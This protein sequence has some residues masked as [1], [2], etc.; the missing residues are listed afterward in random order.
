[1]LKVTILWKIMHFQRLLA[2]AWWLILDIGGIFRSRYNYPS[3]YLG[4]FDTNYIIF[5]IVEVFKKKFVKDNNEFLLK[6]PF[7]DNDENLKTN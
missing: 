2:L 1:M 5:R 6:N 7:D 4:Q 3:N